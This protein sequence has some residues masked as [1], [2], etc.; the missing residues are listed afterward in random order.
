MSW[1]IWIGFVLIF[2]FNVFRKLKAGG[3]PTDKILG[4]N[5]ERE[6]REARLA[7]MLETL[8]ETASDPSARTPPG[9]RPEPAKPSRR[10][11][12]PQPE[13]PSSPSATIA[14]PEEIGK[15]TAAE[16]ERR[17]AEDALCFSDHPLVQG[18]AISE[19]LSLPVALRA[20]ERLV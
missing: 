1:W 19:I 13:K 4:K 11:T 12:A 2:L 14:A 15:I 17:F 10:L 9:K 20:P 3:D 6:A 16:E 18:I 5:A 8:R 7:E